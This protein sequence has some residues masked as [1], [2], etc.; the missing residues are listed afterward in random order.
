MA[1]ME[2]NNTILSEALQMPAEGEL[3][4]PENFVVVEEF[5]VDAESGDM[6]SEKM[7]KLLAN[8]EDKYNG[9]Y[10]LVGLVQEDGSINMQVYASA[11]H[12]EMQK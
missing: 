12:N 2:N 9:E 5:V 6:D 1:D 10:L 4:F 8:L 11:K 3:D 7:S